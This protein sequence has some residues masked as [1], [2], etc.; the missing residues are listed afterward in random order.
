VRSDIRAASSNGEAIRGCSR[1]LDVA[2]SSKRWT[3]CQ[4]V[5]CLISWSTQRL[6][7]L[8]TWTN[9]YVTRT[10]I[11]CWDCIPLPLETKK[12]S[13][14]LFIAHCREELTI[15]KSKAMSNNLIITHISFEGII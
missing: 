3:T 6:K 15:E 8:S 2:D 5:W 4:N 1:W 7:S 11:R 13:K 10:E 9:R 14:L 12:S